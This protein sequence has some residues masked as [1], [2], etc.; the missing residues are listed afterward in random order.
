MTPLQKV[1]M[2]LV[3]VFLSAR[4][5]GYD[6]LPDPIGWGLA[7]A[8]LLPLRSRLPQGGSLLTL[9]AIAGVV[10]VPLVVP[11]VN[12]ALT[13]SGQWGVGIPQ[14]VFCLLLSISLATLAERD[15]EPEAKRFGL[16][17]TA[18]IAVL[19]L[20]VLVYGGGVDALGD[21]DGGAVRVSNV[22]LV[23]YT[24]KVSRRPYVTDAA[25]PQTQVRHKSGHEPRPE[26]RP[27]CGPELARDHVQVDGGV[28]VVVDLDG[29]LVRAERLDRVAEDDLALVDPSTRGARRSRR[30]CHRPSPH[31]TAGRPRRRGPAG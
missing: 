28:D 19:V 20:P 26:C 30:R 14:T 2:G 13:P 29:H 21:T 1:A 7:V 9:A 18:Y 22:A 6:A 16:L 27:E 23:Y 31:R 10:S 24:F 12:E 11:Q 15:G 4:F 17:R 3:I 5:A 25:P 8:G